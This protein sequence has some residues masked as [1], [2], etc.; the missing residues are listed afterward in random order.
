MKTAVLATGVFAA[1]VGLAGCSSGN[2]NG[3]SA[4]VSAGLSNGPAVSLSAGASVSPA[5]SLGIGA[6]PSTGAIGTACQ[7]LK[8]TISNIPSKLER[9]ATAANPAQQVQQTVS[10]ISTT[11]KNEVQNTG[12]QLQNAV[13]SYVDKLQQVVSSLENGN[14]PDLSKLSTT[15]IDNAC[16]SNGGPSVGSSAVPSVSAGVSASTG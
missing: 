5:A 7:N 9:A 15:K 2:T 16:A 8:D 1:A 4:S 6:S 13:Q 3:A 14:A 11:L 10:N 12:D